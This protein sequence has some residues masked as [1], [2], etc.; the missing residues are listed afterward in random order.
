MA[1]YVRCK[2]KV[3]AGHQEDNLGYFGTVWWDTIRPDTKQLVVA[4]FTTRKDAEEQL[5]RLGLD[6]VVSNNLQ[7][8]G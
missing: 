8:E 2:N 3:Y 4:V 1:F 6:A 5:K 7:Y